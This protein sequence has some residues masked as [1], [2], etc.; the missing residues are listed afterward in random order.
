MCDE[1]TLK[2]W[3][4]YLK[5]APP[6]SR[7]KFGALTAGAGLAAAARSHRCRGQLPR[8]RSGNGCR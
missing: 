2:D 5:N 6:V 4:Q 3:A 1:Q 8:R 7:R